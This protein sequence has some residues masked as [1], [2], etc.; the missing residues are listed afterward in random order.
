MDL[1]KPDHLVYAVPDLG[2]A[3][4]DL[5]QRLGVRPTPGGQHPGVGTHNAL[6]SLGSNCY[7]EIIAPD[8][9][10]PRPPRPRPFRLDQRTEAKL[11]TWAARE[12]H[13]A[14]R[15]RFARA[16]GYDPGE[17][18][19]GARDRPDGV[20]LAW[21][22]TKRPE[23]LRGEVPPGD[24]LVPFLIDWGTTPHPAASAAQGCRLVDLRAEHPDPEQIRQ[25]FAALGVAVDIDSG[26]RP[27]L[28][29]TIDAPAGSVEL[30]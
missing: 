5:A 29:A 13:L 25:L 26:P 6:L 19:G 24:G 23:A 1:L 20:R 16:N 7:L 2:Q 12:P 22:T 10:Q 14:E 28:I 27:R 30:D 15:I 17:I 8:P 18:V 9:D 11:A 4:D 3:L 21:R